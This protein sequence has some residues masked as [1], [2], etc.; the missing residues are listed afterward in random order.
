MP[1][2]VSHKME[3]VPCREL[4]LQRDRIDMSELLITPSV[5]VSWI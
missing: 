5:A 2:K 4:R 3:P 1:L